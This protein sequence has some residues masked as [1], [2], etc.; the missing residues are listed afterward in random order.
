MG[1]SYLVGGIAIRDGVSLFFSD[2]CAFEMSYT[3]NNFIYNT[4]QIGDNC[5]L[6]DPTALCAE[7]GVAYWMSDQDFWRSEE[8]T[9]EL[10]SH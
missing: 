1:G 4:P 6:V 9:S 5:G 2:R 7:G 3:G 8:H 10:Q